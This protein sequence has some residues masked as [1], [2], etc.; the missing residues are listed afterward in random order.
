MRYPL[1]LLWLAQDVREDELRLPGPGQRQAA[2]Q[3]V[4]VCL[5]LQHG[6]RDPGRLRRDLVR[7]QLQELPMQPVRRP[8]HLRRRQGACGGSCTDQ[9]GAATTC[10]SYGATI[11]D[12]DRDG[13]PGLPR[14]RPGE[15]VLPGHEPTVQAPW[16]VV[17][18]RRSSTTTSIN[19]TGNTWSQL[20]VTSGVNV[21]LPFHGQQVRPSSLCPDDPND[22]NDD[23]SCLEIRYALLYNHDL[24]DP[25][26]GH[27]HRGDNE[28]YVRVGDAQEARS[29]R[30]AVGHG[31]ERRGRVEGRRPGSSEPTRAS[32]VP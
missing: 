6:L 30:D 11:D 19:S 5:R 24:G 7:Q 31:E 10:A 18:K 28:G 14:A 27:A 12:R 20:F 21:K 25:T 1:Q 26:F 16:R 4:H 22:P 29:L 3:H 17:T 9:V 8:R 32:Q 23:F 13:I 15:E 2:V